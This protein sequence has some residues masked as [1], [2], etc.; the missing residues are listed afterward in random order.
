LTFFAF[1]LVFAFTCSV[2]VLFDTFKC[3]FLKWRSKFRPSNLVRHTE[4]RIHSYGV[5]F[6]AEVAQ[7]PPDSRNCETWSCKEMV[8]FSV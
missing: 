1:T 8:S 7:T 4:H 5:C 3:F 6:G 2:I